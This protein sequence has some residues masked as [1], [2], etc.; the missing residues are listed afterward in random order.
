MGTTSEVAEIVYP[1]RAPEFT[2]TPDL[3]KVRITISLLFLFFFW[4]LYCSGFFHLRLS[5]ITFVCL[6]FTFYENYIDWF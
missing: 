4:S 2:L 5:I 6:T 3:Y 1:S